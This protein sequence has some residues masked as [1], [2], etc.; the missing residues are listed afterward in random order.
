MASFRTYSSCLGTAGADKVDVQAVKK[1]SCF[2]RG[3]S[4]K[5]DVSFSFWKLDFRF[6]NRFHCFSFQCWEVFERPT[7]LTFWQFYHF[8]LSNFSVSFRPSIKLNFFIFLKRK[9]S[10]GTCF[11]S[12]AP[13]LL[14]TFGKKSTSFRNKIGF[15]VS[16]LNQ[17]PWARFELPSECPLV[18]TRTWSDW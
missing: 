1:I 12:I 8:F 9:H 7:F 14:S 11:E 5:S 16:S 17:S 18:F 15:F 10:L 13:K 2:N 6:K 4:N 3:R